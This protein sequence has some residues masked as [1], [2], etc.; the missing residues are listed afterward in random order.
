M[1]EIFNVL[2]TVA[3]VCVIGYFIWLLVM[4]LITLLPKPLGLVLEIV[5]ILM[6]IAVL[7]GFLMGDIPMIHIA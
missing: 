2:L 5:A 3:L 4:K 6:A 1:I 7:F